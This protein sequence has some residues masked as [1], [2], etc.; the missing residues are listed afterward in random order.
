LTGLSPP[1]IDATLKRSAIVLSYWLASN[2]RACNVAAW[3]PDVHALGPGAVLPA[4]LPGPLGLLAAGPLLLP[5]GV[6]RPPTLEPLHPAAS[7]KPS[8]RK[9]PLA[10]KMLMFHLLR[11]RA[12]AGPLPRRCVG[13][14]PTF[15]SARGSRRNDSRP[16]LSPIPF[17]WFG[18]ARLERSF[19]RR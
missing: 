13:R 8:A 15:A 9:V 10:E 17:H 3:G 19:S 2:M 18:G 11:R 4:S 5:P 16:D 1:E 12:S 7:R 6:E 14:R